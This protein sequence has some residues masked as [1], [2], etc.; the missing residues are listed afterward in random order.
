ML[1][2]KTVHQILVIVISIFFASLSY[3]YEVR[4]DF[5]TSDYSSN[6]LGNWNVI[7]NADMNNQVN[8]LIDFATG[9]PT[10]IGIRG[11]DWF[12]FGWQSADWNG[13]ADKN[14]IDYNA[15]NDYFYSTADNPTITFTGL[16]PGQSYSIDILCAYSDSN[17]IM[18]IQINGQFADSN[19]NGTPGQFGDD[20][21]A[22]IQG[23]DA[24]NYLTWNAVVADGS[25][26]IQVSFVPYNYVDLNAARIQG[27]LEAPAPRAVPA[28]TQ[29]GIIV[30]IVLAGVGAVYFIR[31][32]NTAKS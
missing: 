11:A 27:P 21:D 22:L 10:S 30:F 23:F 5:S 28:M 29:W 1:A 32:Q 20:W 4:I 26:E 25:G 3:A 9:L 14:W 6:P 2:S 8:N 31:R 15:A 17:D 13:G 12:G 7:E 24:A 19:A 18:D 16:S